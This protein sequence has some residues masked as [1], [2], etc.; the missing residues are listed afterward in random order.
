MVKSNNLSLASRELEVTTSMATRQSF[1]ASWY[2]VGFTSTVLMMFLCADIAYDSKAN[3][4]NLIAG[5]CFA[6]AT[7][8]IICAV[9][10]RLKSRNSDTVNEVNEVENL[11]Q[12]NPLFE[13]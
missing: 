5:L 3:N 13:L 12:I 4:S 8:A 10:M 2:L 7:I 6:Y 1:V 9:F 11:S